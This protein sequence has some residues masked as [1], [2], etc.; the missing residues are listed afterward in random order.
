MAVY[1]YID[2]ETT[3]KFTYINNHMTKPEIVQLSFIQA[4]ENSIIQKGDSYFRC[5][6]EFAIGASMVNGLSKRKLLGLADKEFDDYLP[7]IRNLLKTSD[8]LVGH[9]VAFE[10]KVLSLYK[11]CGIPE[12]VNSKA[13]ICTQNDY[14]HIFG[15]VIQGEHG[16]RT[17]WGSLSELLSILINR[18]DISL[19]Q[20]YSGYMNLFGREPKMHDSA[21]DVYVCYTAHQTLLRRGLSVN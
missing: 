16:R 6:G 4:T 2:T 18:F 13:T 20:L 12:L 3:D 7:Y 19:D 14:T 11:G 8:Y 15:K 9:N 10:K 5:N 21:F 1:L 17:A